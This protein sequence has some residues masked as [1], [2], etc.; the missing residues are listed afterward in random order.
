MNTHAHGHTRI[1]THVDMYV[2]NRVHEAFAKSGATVWRYKMK[3]QKILMCS[4]A[5]KFKICLFFFLK[6]VHF[7]KFSNTWSRGKYFYL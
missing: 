1:G 5:L 3:T 7:T 4:D 6:K 2:N